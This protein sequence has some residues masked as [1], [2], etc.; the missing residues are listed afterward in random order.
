MRMKAASFIV[1]FLS[2]ILSVQNQN[3]DRFSIVHTYSAKLD[4]NNSFVIY[5]N[6]INRL[7][8]LALC[9]SIPK[10]RTVLFF[11]NGAICKIYSVTEYFSND[12]QQTNI[13]VFNRFTQGV[14][15]N[16]YSFHS[17]AAMSLVKLNNGLLASG[18]LDNTIK[19]FDTS[20]GIVI[21][22]LS[23]NNYPCDYV[24]TLRVLKND[25][26]A[27]GCG[28]D[29]ILILNISNFS[30]IQILSDHSG[31]IKYLFRINDQI[32]ASG[33]FD[34]T[35][36]LWNTTNGALF[37]TLYN[38]TA[39]VF[40][41]AVLADGN[42]ASGSDDLS[43]VI[44]NMT[45]FSL[46]NKLMGHTGGILYL[47]T[48]KNGN[49][50]S[51]SGDLTIRIWNVLIGQTIM[52]LRGHTNGIRCLLLY[53]ENVLISGSIDGS[54]KLWDLTTGQARM[55]LLGHT[56]K[57]MSIVKLENGS[58]VSGAYDKTIKIWNL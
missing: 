37:Y 52:I 18:S 34:N 22:D 39:Q 55:T 40:S 32:L 58:I 15:I 31:V 17:N 8:C 41:L 11:E 57:V 48:V 6:S 1:F 35:I 50:V 20:K 42:L 45:T 56:D 25:I 36:K 26:I 2:I 7:K 43:I 46:Q 51:A 47:I 21:G 44:W 53:G 38:H 4:D 19:I 30:L 5:S 16:T 33:S 29:K 24:H 54:M 49:L 23:L 12:G 3:S 27:C 13:T 28:T 14:S 10:C 9:K